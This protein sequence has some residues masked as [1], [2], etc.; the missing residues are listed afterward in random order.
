MSMKNLSTRQ[1]WQFLVVIAISVPLSVLAQ[2]N[3]DAL[4]KWIALNDQIRLNQQH[5]FCGEWYNNRPKGFHAR[6]GGD[7]P[8]TIARLSIQSQPNAAGIYTARWTYKRHPQQE[9]FSS[10]FPDQCTAAQIVQS[11][12]YAV[13][14]G[15]S[16][17][18]TGSPN[19]AQ[20]GQNG[21]DDDAILSGQYCS[22]NGTRFTIAF[23][24][25]QAGRINTAFPLFE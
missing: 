17:C 12:A 7:N 10:M 21:P 5:V 19:W 24:P 8:A 1:L 9:K 4:P 14:L 11:I 16:D 23:A 15:K 13:T 6:P 25:P 22:V 2:T 18:P 20:C 3:C